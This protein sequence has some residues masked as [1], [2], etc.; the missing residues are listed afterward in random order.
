MMGWARKRPRDEGGMKKRDGEKIRCSSP[1]RA[2]L[3]NQ[4]RS[5]TVFGKVVGPPPH[6]QLGHNGA[7]LSLGTQHE[8]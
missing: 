8:K 6:S 4:R 7:G 2:R 1:A 3:I 5:S